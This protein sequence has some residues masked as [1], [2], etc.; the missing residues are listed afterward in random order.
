[1]QTTHSLPRNKLERIDHSLRFGESFHPLP[2]SF[3]VV[4]LAEGHR[5]CIANTRAADRLGSNTNFQL[6]ELNRSLRFLPE[7]PEPSGRLVVPGAHKNSPFDDN[8]P[9]PCVAVLSSGAHA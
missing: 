7:R 8:N 1:M 2:R 9:D 3:R 6:P 4:L 5:D